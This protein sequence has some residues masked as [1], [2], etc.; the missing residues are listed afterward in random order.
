MK[1]SIKLAF[2]AALAVA[3]IAACTS[4]P[5]PQQNSAPQSS[6]TSPTLS[7]APQT[8]TNSPNANVVVKADNRIGYGPIKIGMTLDE[9][10]AAGLTDLTWQSDGDHLCVADDELAI[11]KRYGVV[12]IS[13]PADART[14]TG[15]GVGS[16]FADVK[17]A[18]PNA[19][20]YRSGWSA[21]V[22]EN[23]GYA[24]LGEPGSDANKVVGVKLISRDADCSMAYL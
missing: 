11:S 15:I 3:G 13:L 24:F 14:S 17:K 12:R 18:Y 9:A 8:V 7:S 10:R 2:F 20:E 6:S 16:T 19:S 22:N 5:A 4:T 21:R 1:N 23:V